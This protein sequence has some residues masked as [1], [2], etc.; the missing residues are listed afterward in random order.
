MRKILF[1]FFIL[2]IALFAAWFYAEKNK[3]DTGQKRGVVAMPSSFGNF[4]K[5]NYSFS[6]DTDL[7]GMSDAK[8]IIYGSDPLKLDTD[9][10]GF[11]DG[12]EVKAGFDPLVSGKNKG[13]LSERKNPNISVQYFTWLQKKIHT[14]DPQIEETE[15]KRFLEEKGL[16]R[17]SLPPVLENDTKFTNEDAQK[18]ADYLKL[19]ASL[20]LPEEGSPYL[21]LA[22]DLIK[23][24]SINALYDLLKTVGDELDRV[25]SAQVPPS[26]LELHQHYLGVWKELKTVFESLKNAQTDPV[27]VYISQKK[28]E[29]LTQEIEKTEE[30]RRD[31]IA[32]IKLKPFE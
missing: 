16:L 28:G 1:I 32:K 9:G 29:W 24:K 13:R 4:L 11:S 25:S 20:A 3:T 23:N 15:V 17:F 22:G 26:L 8:E 27:A 30:L 12:E 19:T 7:D 5:A 10:D 18:I 21:A 14:I 2:L 6:T 31:Y